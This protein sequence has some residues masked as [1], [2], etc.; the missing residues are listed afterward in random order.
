M[1]NDDGRRVAYLGK[2]RARLWEDVIG[3]AR[4]AAKTYEDI[5]T[6]AEP[7]PCRG[8]ILGLARTAARVGDD[9]ALARA[10]L[11]EARLSE[12]GVDVLSLKTRAAT[13][14]SRV[15]HSRALALVGEVLT[16]E[17]AH[18]TAARALETR[19]HEEARRW[20]AAAASIRKRI[21]HAPK[22]A[23][24]SRF[25]W[26]SAQ[27]QDSRLHAPLEALASLRA[28]PRP[29]PSSSR[30]AGSHRAHARGCGRLHDAMRG[31]R[32]TRCGRTDTGRTGA[33][34]P[35]RSRDP[36]NAV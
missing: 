7:R 8:A 4:R 6:L 34:P 20:D 27:V 2:D 21:D 35:A 10:L 3:D 5:L 22:H 15:D 33:S 28:G 9:R 17:P 36:G 24:R 12:D 11:D 26:R 23:R 32:A 31:T 16:T 1:R 18:A 13:A 25:G 30:S 14:L 29:R 19:I